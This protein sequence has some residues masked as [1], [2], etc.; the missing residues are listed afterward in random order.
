LAGSSEGAT[1]SVRPKCAKDSGQYQYAQNVSDPNFPTAYSKA[2]KD[3]L[4]EADKKAVRFLIQ[5]IE[6]EEEKK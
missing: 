6:C 4:S 5:E 1:Q 3:D 2:I